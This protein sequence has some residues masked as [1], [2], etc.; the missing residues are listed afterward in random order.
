[1]IE[2]G[3]SSIPNI[4]TTN[5]EPLNSTARLAVAP[6]APIASY[7]SRPPSRSSR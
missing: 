3:T 6:A 1:M 7:G 2:E 5:A 4:A